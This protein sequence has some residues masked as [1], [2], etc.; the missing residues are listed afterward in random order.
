MSPEKTF[1]CSEIGRE[2]EESLSILKAEVTFSLFRDKDSLFCFRIREGEE[3]TLRCPKIRKT[4]RVYHAERSEEER[5]G[6]KVCIPKPDSKQG[7]A[8][9]STAIMPEEA[10]G[11]YVFNQRSVSNM[12]RLA[13][14]LKTF[15]SSIL[16]LVSSWFCRN[17]KSETVLN[18][19]KVRSED[20]SSS[21]KGEEL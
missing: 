3:E 9:S 20:V 16:H 2:Q 6:A 4:R 19:Q 7:K 15:A 18:V 12:L 8:E 10:S 11:S 1:P 14:P 21:E 17:C 13:H 5:N